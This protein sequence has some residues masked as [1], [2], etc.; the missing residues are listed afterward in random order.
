MIRMY[1]LTLAEFNAE[2][3]RASEE[4]Y[5]QLVNA[6][7]QVSDTEVRLIIESEGN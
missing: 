5:R 1:T 7:K 2:L 3:K 6:A 4:H